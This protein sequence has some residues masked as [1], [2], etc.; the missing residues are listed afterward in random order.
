MLAVKRWDVEPTFVAI[1]KKCRVELLD[2]L[3][4]AGEQGGDLEHIHSAVPWLPARTHRGAT[5]LRHT[6]GLG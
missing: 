5:A 1:A 3:V 2:H 6:Q 4:G